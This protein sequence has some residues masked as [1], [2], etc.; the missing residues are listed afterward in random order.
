[1]ADALLVVLYLVNLQPEIITSCCGVL[2]GEQQ[3]GGYSLFNYTSESAVL[4]L[5]TGTA[6]VLLSGS[7]VQLRSASVPR[8]AALVGS[9]LLAPA[10]VGFYLLALAVVTVQVSPYVYGVPHHRCP[11]DLLHYPYLMI[12]LPLY[13][14]LHGAV[15]SGLGGALA[16]VLSPAAG[17]GS[18]M[19]R[20]RRRASL[21]S[22]AMLLLF[23]LEPLFEMVN[24]LRIRGDVRWSGAELLELL[25]F[26]RQLILQRGGD[27]GFFPFQTGDF[28]GGVVLHLVQLRHGAAFRPREEHHEEAGHAGEEEGLDGGGELIP[29]GEDGGE[30]VWEGSRSV[31]EEERDAV[32]E[33]DHRHRNGDEAAK[34]EDRRGG[35]KQRA[36]QEVGKK[37]GVADVVVALRHALDP[38]LAENPHHRKQAGVFPDKTLREQ[39]IA[40]PAKEE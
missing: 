24:L 27:G 14:F 3:E 29:H 35:E 37:G 30:Q 19:D 23:L 7:A 8:R 22:I 10:W 6:L 34:D 4:L 38:A 39:A 40:H 15:V 33:V 26:R 17:D 18:P 9:A 36:T 16:G 28:R 13:L 21:L 5:L 11:F 12:G 31:G 2:F 20:F 1:M 25:V 32:G